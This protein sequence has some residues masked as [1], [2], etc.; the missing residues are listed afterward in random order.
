VFE[1]TLVLND[2]ANPSQIR[3]SFPGDPE[4]FPPSYFLD[5]ET[6]ENDQVRLV[7]V[8]NS[9]L[10][11]ALD[12][13]IWRVNYLPSERDSSFDRGKAMAPISKT[14]GC[15][16]PMCACTFSMDGA[17][18]L[19]AFVSDSGIHVTDGYSFRTV[20]D[21]LDWRGIISTTATTNNYALINNREEQELIFYFRNN[22]LANGGFRA[23]H[24]S[25]SSDHV[26]N[27][28]LKISGMVDMRNTVGA[29]SAN[30]RSAWTVQRTSG[31]TNVYLGFGGNSTAAGAGQVYRENGTT[32]PVAD[33]T[34]GYVTRRMYLAGMGNEWEGAEIYGYCGSYTGTPIITYTAQNTKTNDAGPVTVYSKT[35]TLGGQKLH[36]IEPRFL[37]EGMQ[38]TAQITASAFAQEALIIEGEQFGVE[39]SGR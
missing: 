11:V 16:N 15:V 1:D 7:K 32:L 30:I 8:V 3:W 36:K 28:Q 38:I 10:I 4:S 18:E 37:F 20:T 19:L 33:D 14:Y 9:S 17:T 25:Y 5:F 13:S 21:G 2:V 39:D 23:L 31:E 29:N 22:A 34:M 24:L 6:R 35:V 12:A 27:G 26:A